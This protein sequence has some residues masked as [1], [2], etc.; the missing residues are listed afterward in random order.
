MKTTA[1]LFGL[2]FVLAATGLGQG[3]TV[4]NAT[5]AKFQQQRLAAEREYRDNYERLGF[6]SP[7]ELDRQREKDLAA[8]L[9]LAEQLR[10]ERLEKER[11][12]LERKSL[13]VEAASAE[14]NIEINLNDR[15]SLGGYYPAWTGSG[16]FYDRFG[17]RRLRHRFPPLGV[18]SRRDQFHVPVDRTG[19]YRVTPFGVI[20]TPRYDVPRGRLRGGFWR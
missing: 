1:V 18:F 15:G 13:E 6:P 14:A 8:R 10:Q 19:A 3:R 9:K 12:E 20:P 17:H 11:L 16:V 2:T 7:E 4:T 5:L